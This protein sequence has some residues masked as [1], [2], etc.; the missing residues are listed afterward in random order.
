VLESK[1]E[2]QSEER[3]VQPGPHVLVAGAYYMMDQ[4]GPHVLSLV[5][6]M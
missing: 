6:T 5:H 3:E 4:P 2:V 1:A